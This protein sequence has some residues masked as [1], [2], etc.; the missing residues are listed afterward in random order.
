MIAT[1]R[2][3]RP[4]YPAETLERPKRPDCPHCGS[5]L[6]VAEQ[7]RFNLTGRIDHFWACDVCGTEFETSIEVNRPGSCEKRCRIGG[8]Q[9]PSPLLP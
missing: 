8:L 6:L 5:R 1:L 7:S 2:L 4:I 3:E 9:L